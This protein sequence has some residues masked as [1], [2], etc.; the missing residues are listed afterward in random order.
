MQQIPVTISVSWA[1]S[2]KKSEP[3]FRHSQYF[4]FAAGSPHTCS[5]KG[6]IPN[7]LISVLPIKKRAKAYQN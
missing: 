1:F 5:N 7:A 3:G 6:S 4:A 2:D